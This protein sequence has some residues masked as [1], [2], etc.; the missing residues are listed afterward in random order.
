MTATIITVVF[1][2]MSI[3]P[4]LYVIALVRA[5]LICGYSAL[6]IRIRKV[7]RRWL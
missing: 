2:L 4:A 7:I 6:R 3:I 5:L 1:V